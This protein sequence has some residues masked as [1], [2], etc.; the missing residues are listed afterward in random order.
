[1]ILEYGRKG[2]YTGCYFGAMQHFEA[3][4]LSL[5]LLKSERQPQGVCI[6]LGGEYLTTDGLQLQPVPH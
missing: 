3:T 1:M 2:I 5:E 6:Y 4:W